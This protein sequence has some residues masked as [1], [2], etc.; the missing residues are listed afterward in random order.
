MKNK[1]NKKDL[2]CAICK[3]PF[4]GLIFIPSCGH[5]SC[6]E[7]LIQLI[8]SDIDINRNVVYVIP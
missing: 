7:C 4:I 3:E 1:I 8:N 2:I 5:H 6:R